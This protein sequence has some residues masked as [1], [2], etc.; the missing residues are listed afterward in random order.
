MITRH[1]GFS[2]LE[3]L[4]AFGIMAVALT[5]VLRIFGSGVNAAL[6]SED[7]TVAVQLAESLMARTG[8]ET[9]LTAGETSGSEIDKFHWSVIIKP[10]PTPAFALPHRATSLSRQNTSPEQ[11]EENPLQLASVQ[12]L[13]RWGD[14]EAQR[15]RVLELKTIKLFYPQDL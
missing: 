2:L 12:V 6:N 4:V 9:P 10:L 8:I 7:Y 3:V 13:V 11:M 15:S 14:E 5:I 1:K